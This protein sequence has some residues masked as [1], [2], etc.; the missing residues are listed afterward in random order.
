MIAIECAS[1]GVVFGL[2][3]G[4]H[5]RRREDHE[6]FKCPNGHPNVYPKPKIT[7]EQKKIRELEQTVERRAQRYRVTLDVLEDW[8]R[9]AR[10]CPICETR[11]TTAQFIETIRAKVAEHLRDEHGARARLRSIAEKASVA[12]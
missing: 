5:A 4:Y 7:E 6:G 10:V 9:A 8:K 2:T 11:V 1:C 12:Q 3:E